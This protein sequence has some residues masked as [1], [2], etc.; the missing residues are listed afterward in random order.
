M[1]QLQRAGVPCG[2]VQSG[3]DLLA[4]PHLRERGFIA[5]VDHR[6]LGHM[7]VA[8]VP[9]RLSGGGLE[10]PR[11]L[12]D[13]GRHNEYVYCELL[14]YTRDQLRVWQETGIVR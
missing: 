4:D 5:G 12:A 13:L 1:D 10:P 14:G 8:A 9:M 11:W 3:D 2:V 6:T 7:P